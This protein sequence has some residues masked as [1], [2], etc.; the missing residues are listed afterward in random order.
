MSHH[1]INHHCWQCCHLPLSLPTTTPPPPP[2]PSPPCLA[3]KANG[4]STGPN[5][6]CIVWALCKFFFVCQWATPGVG[7]PHGRHLPT[8]WHMPPHWCLPNPLWPRHHSTEMADHDH[9]YH[10]WH[11]T[12]PQPHEQ[13]LMGRMVHGLMTTHHPPLA[14]WATVDAMGMMGMWQGWQGYN[15]DDR[16]VTGVTGMWQRWQRCNRDDKDTTGMWWGWMR[17]QEDACIFYFTSFK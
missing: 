12:C 4:C 8:L 5:D 14:P 1:N 2:S 17:G 16:D 15:R 7:Y 10:G 6:H 9:T 3:V 11:P 13:L